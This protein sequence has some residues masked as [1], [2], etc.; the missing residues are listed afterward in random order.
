MGVNWLSDCF[1]RIRYVI[2]TGICTNASAKINVEEDAWLIPYLL[3]ASDNPTAKA[4]SSAHRI[5]LL[6]L[7]SFQFNFFGNETRI[8][9]RI[10]AAIKSHW[11]GSKCSWLIKREKNMV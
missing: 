1:S 8:M 2:A 6:L 7:I 4:P 11:R 9:P 5:K 10:I 3:N